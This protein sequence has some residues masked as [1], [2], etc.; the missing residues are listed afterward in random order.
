MLLNLD[1][2]LLSASFNTKRNRQF[3][4]VNITLMKKL[5]STTFGTIVFFIGWAILISF[6]P[7]IKTDNNA[8]LRLWWEFTSL[9][10]VILFT[11][12]F[13]FI[14]KKRRIEISIK[15]RFTKNLILGI[16]VGL[17]WLGSVFSVLLL[18]SSIHIESY[19]NV[20][21]LWVW[22]LACLLNVI[23]QELLV[24]G[25]LYQL[26]KNNYN[27]IVAAIFTTALFT[28]MHGGVF[29]AGFIA[30][31]NV[32]TMSIFVTL[33]LE[34]TGTLLAPII[35]HFVWNAIGAILLGGVSLASDYPNLFNITF[36]GNSLIS[37]D[38]YKMEG[39]IVTLVINLIL[40]IIFYILNQNKKSL[41]R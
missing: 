40:I 27:T 32:I 19:N 25:Y 6:T 12:I 30:V 11:F 26:W 23:M 31:L 29:E 34:Y 36:E 37:G 38:I 35:V 17:L 39:S 10:A 15:S 8:L 2:N 24:R 21:Y 20:N 1:Y 16:V 28:F 13:V 22:I 3:G 9:I 18:T 7:D 4:K 14:I 33:L 41:A 5:I